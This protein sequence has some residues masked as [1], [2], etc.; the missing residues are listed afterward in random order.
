MEMQPLPFWGSARDDFET[1]LPALYSQRA[2]EGNSGP[3]PYEVEDVELALRPI[4]ANRMKAAGYE[5][6][7]P[8]EPM[9]GASV[10]LLYRYKSTNTDT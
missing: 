10:Y 1:I 2:V 9:P 3:T 5:D 8:P 4:V 7:T 6:H